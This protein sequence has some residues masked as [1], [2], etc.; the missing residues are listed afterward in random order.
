MYKVLIADDEEMIRRGI[1]KLVGKDEEIEVVGL[2]E[3]GEEA[4]ELA[5][6]TVPDVLLVDINMPFLNGLQLIEKVKGVLPDVVVLIITGYDDFAYAQKA[7]RL[8]VFEYVL[9]PLCEKTFYEAMERAKSVVDQKKTV[10]STLTWSF[11]QIKVH[12]Q[13]IVGHLFESFLEHKLDAVAL[14]EQ[15]SYLKQSLPQTFSLVLITLFG[16]EKYT[17]FNERWDAQLLGY[18]CENI[19][20]ETLARY[21]PVLVFERKEDLVLIVEKDCK[22]ML[23]RLAHNIRRILPT[24]VRIV[25]RS[26]VEIKT[27]EGVYHEL[28]EEVRNTK[29]ESDTVK[30]IK[31]LIE[32]CFSDATF[33]IQ[34]LGEMMHMTPQYLSRIFKHETG[35]T[36][37]EYLSR[38]RIQ[39]ACELLRDGSLKMYEIAEA[40]GYAN[41]HYFSNAFK[42]IMGSSPVAYK[43]R[44]SR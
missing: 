44:I 27:L 10:N 36:I 19:A 40:I 12:K 13:Q 33:S 32:Q 4:L 18:A 26:Y 37:G 17:E 5:T 25:S 43:R 16:Q 38:M 39:R 7:L 34:E 35:D 20:L 30:Q 41:Q 14:E 29:C 42:K 8:G 9:K 6:H 24:D 3:D 22:E 28:Y 23:E 2:A 31:R 11:E 21:L 1:A 15:L